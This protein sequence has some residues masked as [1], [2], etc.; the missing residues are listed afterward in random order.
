MLQPLME[1]GIHLDNLSS[2][3]ESYAHTSFFLAHCSTITIKYELY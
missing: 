1:Y 3:F 2:V